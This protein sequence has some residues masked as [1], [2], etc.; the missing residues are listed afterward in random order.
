[1]S[2]TLIDRIDI[3]LEYTKHIPDLWGLLWRGLYCSHISVIL[4]VIKQ[5]KNFE[6]MVP[7]DNL[8]ISVKNKDLDFFVELYHHIKPSIN[9]PYV[10]HEHIALRNEDIVLYILSDNP[11][12]ITER[13][14]SLLLIYQLSKVLKALPPLTDKPIII[15]D[16]IT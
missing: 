16:C 6:Y 15:T 3:K 1:M 13:V 2:F 5:F 9:L 12:E 7:W 14:I 4:H 10:L 11:T 8:M